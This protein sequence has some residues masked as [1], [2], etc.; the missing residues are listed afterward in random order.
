MAQII[1]EGSLTAIYPSPQLH[2][3]L[4]QL[5]NSVTVYQQLN[6]NTDDSGLKYW[7]IQGK[8]SVLIA[9]LA[10]NSISAKADITEH[11]LR[12][13]PAI[14]ELT[15]E[16]NALLPSLMQDHA[17]HLLPI[18]LLL[19]ETLE[20]KQTIH[21][22][23]QGLLAI[24]DVLLTDA[25]GKV[26]D[27]YLGIASSDKVRDFIH[28]HF[29]SEIILNTQNGQQITLNPEQEKSL[30]AG[31]INNSAQS[32][33]TH[34]TKLL[35]GVAGSGKSTVLV[36]RAALLHSLN[37]NARILI[38]SHN[39]AMSNVLKENITALTGK[40]NNIQCHPFMEWCRKLL[41]GTWQFVYDDQE[42]ELFDLMVKRHFPRGE[43]NRH[44]L[45]REVNFIKNHAIA[46]ESEYIDSLSS[47]SSY[48]LANPIRK[49][50]WQTCIDIDTH[51]KDRKRYLWSNAPGM[52]INEL[53]D[54]KIFEPYTHVLIDETHY[55]AQVWIKLVQRVMA[56]NSQLF[57]AADS[58]YNFSGRVLSWH[59]TGIE[60]RGNTINLNK[61][62]RCN[63]AICKVADGFRVNRSLQ[64]LNNPLCLT[65][66]LELLDTETQP[67]LLQF[68]SIK[69]QKRRLFSE[70]H[71]LVNK[72]IPPQEILVLCA[73]KQVSRL[74]AQEI[75]QEINIPAT[76]LTGSMI[77][78]NES[79]KL[80][81]ME[82]A[83]GLE[84]RV[85]FI[86]GIE[87]LMDLENSPN[88]NA[89]DRRSLKV[90]HTHLLHMAMTRA[91]EHL[92]LLITA[93]EI[94][95]EWQIDGLI[96]P[97]LSTDRRAPV[98]YLNTKASAQ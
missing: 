67:K 5:P 19:P 22:K 43:V 9:T 11:T 79:I 16:R 6:A 63:K 34:S 96:T 17:Q 18:I 94:P 86:T 52:L 50:I 69:D 77:V 44:S 66:R 87:E 89:H 31:L 21:L 53:D 42:T 49:R 92:Y 12:H 33:T 55:F 2:T 82:S 8:Q 32:E 95:E 91:S 98:T 56:N 47:N 40:N 36:K 75:K 64:T 26:L 88:A 74:L 76:A 29:C 68:P 65:N 23:D 73:S 10:D 71:Q 7:V 78:N 83:T 85:V 39:K 61:T 14:F 28:T 4:A 1:P 20:S 15:Q 97:T 38:L 41:G 93:S 30:K 90:E 48:A 62:Y 72:G 84:S 51:L 58:A 60:L 57:L 59:E 27:R 13:L 35:L 81:D 70:I 25:L 80:C 46:S 37:P 45:V 24:G 54:G 3:R